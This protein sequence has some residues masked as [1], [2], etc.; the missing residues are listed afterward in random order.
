MEFNL[1]LSVAA[2]V[3][4]CAKRI[5]SSTLSTVLPTFQMLFKLVNPLLIFGIASS[6]VTSHA[7]VK[8]AVRIKEAPGSDGPL[9]FKMIIRKNTAYLTKEENFQRSMILI[10]HHVLILDSASFLLL[11]LL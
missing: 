1:V 11:P 2:I 9:N 3:N 5:Q 8:A 7:M 6:S 4:L 10:Y